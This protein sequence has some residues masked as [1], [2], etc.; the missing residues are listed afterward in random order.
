MD[1]KVKTTVI[2]SYPAVLDNMVF[3]DDY[4]NQNESSWNKIIDYAVDDMVEAGVDII[5]NFVYNLN[6][7]SNSTAF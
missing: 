6:S 3:M 1:K 5:S 2:G 7:I 4:F